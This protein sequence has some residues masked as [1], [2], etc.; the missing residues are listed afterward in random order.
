MFRVL[1]H[2]QVRENYGSRWKPKGGET[3]VIAR[4]EQAPTEE[5]L[6]ALVEDRSSHVEKPA[7]WSATHAPD[8]DSSIGD[9]YEHVIGV[10]VVGP[11]YISADQEQELKYEGWCTIFPDRTPATDASRIER[12]LALRAEGI[13]L[14]VDGESRDEYWAAERGILG[15]SEDSPE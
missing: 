10:E 5:E 12:G 7:S 2:T 14:K 8:D 13:I 11:D 4:L 6:A 3:Y 1:A 15:I 9:Y